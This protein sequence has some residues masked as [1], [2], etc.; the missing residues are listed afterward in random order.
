[1]EKQLYTTLKNIWR[2]YQ[3]EEQGCFLAF[4]A[5]LFNYIPQL[6]AW[7]LADVEYVLNLIKRDFEDDPEQFARFLK[8]KPFG[9]QNRFNDLVFKA[10]EYKYKNGEVSLRYVISQM[11]SELAQVPPPKFSDVYSSYG[12][13]FGAMTMLVEQYC[14]DIIYSVENPLQ[15]SKLNT[16]DWRD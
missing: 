16:S 2:S 1:M 13:G 5:A 15:K 10:I 6:S 11:W 14:E 4:A 9:W 12:V 7:T 8:E 3:N